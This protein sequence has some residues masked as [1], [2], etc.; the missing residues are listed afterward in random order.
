MQL[1]TTPYEI[2]VRYDDDGV[3]KGAHVVMLSQFLDDQGAVLG[4]HIG[5]AQALGAGSHPSFKTV[6]GQATTDAFAKHAEVVERNTQLEQRIENE[7]GTQIAE[8]E[9]LRAENSTLRAQLTAASAVAETPAEKS[10]FQK[11]FG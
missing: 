11:L 3:F 6:L 8:L 10:F 2:L 7:I 4:K 9:A 1:K 5:H